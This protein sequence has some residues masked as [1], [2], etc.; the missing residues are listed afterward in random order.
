MSLFHV[1][2]AVIVA[3]SWGFNFIFVKLG[4][5]E[6]PPLLLCA[7]RFL[8]VS[9]PI[10]F[11]VKRPKVPFRQIL[12]Y[13][14]FTF[15]IQFSLLFLGLKL[16]MPAGASSLIFQ[17]QIFFSLF[18]AAFAFKEMPT[19]PQLFGGLV[20]FIGIGCVWSDI[21][22]S[23]TMIGLIL[24]IIAAAS[25]AV[26]NAFSKKIGRVNSYSLV[27]W[28][29]LVSTPP[30]LLLSFII[31][32]P[33]LIFTSLK[34]VSWIGVMSVAYT[35]YISTGVGYVLWNKLLSIYPVSSVIPFTLLIPIF[36]LFGSMVVFNEPLSKMTMFAALFIIMGLAINIFGGKITARLKSRKNTDAETSFA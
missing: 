11:V 23:S 32:G 22:E 9:I 10:V 34:H 30:L 28:G 17:T 8:L 6:L 12:C 1:L 29:C 19:R 26:G 4:L 31:D 3:A 36:G 14:L 5:N 16:G 33:T 21:G 35:T 25:W 2:L 27:A 18:V 13:G 24:E 7:I 15:A 20:A